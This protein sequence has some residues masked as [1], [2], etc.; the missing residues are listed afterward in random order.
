M[1]ITKLL[2]V[3][4]FIATP[5]VADDL[6][7]FKDISFGTDKNEVLGKLNIES[8]STSDTNN[9]YFVRNYKLGDR[10]VTLSIT[11]DDND[12]FYDFSFRF[13][14]NDANGIENII[15]GD[16]S[17]IS[18]VF[19]DKYKKPIK[20]YRLTVNKILFEQTMHIHKEWNNKKCEAYTAIAHAGNEFYA[21]SVVKD[22]KLE[23]AQDAR[24]MKKSM[25]S[26]NKASKDF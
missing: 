8:K 23:K 21:I 16:L 7:K 19:T 17:F 14:R 12:R 15:N 9:T 20:T 2:L 22:I 18:D 13:N 6:C 1:K 3:L 5:A 24:L 11:F 4:V 10:E 25:D 26:Q